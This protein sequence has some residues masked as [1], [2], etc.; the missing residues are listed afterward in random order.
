[1]KKIWVSG[2]LAYD[3][4]MNYG[5]RFADHIDVSKVHVLSLSFA[6]EKLELN[7]GGVAG[8]IAYNLSLLK[9]KPQ[10]IANLGQDGRDYITRL[11]NFGA[12]VTNVQVLNNKLTAGAYTITDK[13]D[14]QITGFFTG[15]MY[16]T[17]KFPNPTSKD[18]AIIGAEYP[19]N[20]VRLARLY[21]KKKTF[22]IFDPAQ[23]IPALSRSQLL[24]G[25]RGASVIIGN[26]YE[27]ALMMKK[28]GYRPKKNQVI[29]STL[30]GKGSVI[31]AGKRRIK[32]PVVKSRKVVD[33]TGAG[34]A[35]RAGL[36]KGLV[37]G[38]S[39]E[40]AGRLASLVASKAVAVYGTQNHKFSWRSIE[41]AYSW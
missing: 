7:T 35:Y 25:M 15:A 3:R 18:L 20:M 11:K 13:A 24:V 30:G 32:I 10:V 14:N 33:P 41:K 16:A 22:Y 38:Y 26:D 17:A 28:S 6:V 37:L 31:L 9:E 12:G 29:I 39:Y 4:I 1:M 19:E 2:S 40:R 21:A 27:I 23:Q 5:G 34:D 8:N 36:I